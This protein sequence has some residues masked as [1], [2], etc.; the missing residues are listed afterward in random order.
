[1]LFLSGTDIPAVIH[2]LTCRLHS[3]SIFPLH[4]LIKDSWNF[5]LSKKKYCLKM[6]CFFIC[7]KLS[8]QHKSLCKS[9]AKM[10]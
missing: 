4:A 6:T 5:E 8:C 7:K 2:V 10:H 1:M 3:C 9:Y